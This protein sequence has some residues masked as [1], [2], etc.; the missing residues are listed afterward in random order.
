MTPLFQFTHKSTSQTNESY[1]CFCVYLSS[2]PTS[3][4]P[5]LSRCLFIVEHQGIL[6]L[7]IQRSTRRCSIW[8]M[9]DIS[10]SAISASTK[11]N[12]PA[13]DCSFVLYVA[14]GSVSIA[15]SSSNMRQLVA[16]FQDQIDGRDR[17]INL[18]VETKAAIDSVVP[19]ALVLGM[20]PWLHFAIHRTK[21]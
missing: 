18:L 20:T 8:S 14:F 2:D 11:W 12:S 1:C 9:E 5:T 10:A 16:V 13:V 4:V 17:V 3:P 6:L 19:I 21:W 7:I 15:V